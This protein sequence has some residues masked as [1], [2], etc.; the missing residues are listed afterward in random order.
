MKNLPTGTA[1]A[2]TDTS[3]RVRKLFE[4]RPLMAPTPHER[5]NRSRKTFAKPAA[6]VEQP[7]SSAD[8][9]TH[10]SEDNDGPVAGDDAREE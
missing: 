8:A 6:E 7:E 3:E 1:Q 4:N 2:V 10:G 5:Q 9:E